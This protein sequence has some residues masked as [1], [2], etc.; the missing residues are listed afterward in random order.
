MGNESTESLIREGLAYLTAFIPG[1]DERGLIESKH[2]IERIALASAALSSGRHSVFAHSY[3]GVVEG[4]EGGQDPRPARVFFYKNS[5]DLA[6]S[7]PSSPARHSDLQAALRRMLILGAD[8]IFRSVATK[9]V[10]SL[11]A[12]L[13]AEQKVYLATLTASGELDVQPGIIAKVHAAL[14]SQQASAVGSITPNLKEAAK[15]LKAFDALVEP[16]IAEV[17]AK[18]MELK[19][20]RNGFVS[21]YFNPLDLDDD[22]GITAAG[23]AALDQ[24]RGPRTRIAASVTPGAI[25]ILI[26]ALQSCIVCIS[27]VRARAALFD[28]KNNSVVEYAAKSLYELEEEAVDESVRV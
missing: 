14:G 24:A 26:M 18:Q 2:V 7:I 20:M 22:R 13:T 5:F 10:S 4:D 11:D 28:R 27:L 1:S 6:A 19:V 21:R 9:E 15:T 23:R 3:D 25:S 16:L 8:T 17:R 12:G